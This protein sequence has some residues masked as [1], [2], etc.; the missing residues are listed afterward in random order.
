MKAKLAR[1]AGD[2]VY[3]WDCGDAIAGKPCSH[4]NPKHSA[5]ER[6]EWRSAWAKLARDAGDA[7][8]QWDRGDAI[9]GKPCSGKNQKH[10]ALERQE[11]S[12]EG[13]PSV[14]LRCGPR[15]LSKR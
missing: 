9:A 12:G 7:V 1:D 15:W 5:L 8:Y 14:I 2:A 13:L 4:K 10:S 3:Q 6:Q 11:W